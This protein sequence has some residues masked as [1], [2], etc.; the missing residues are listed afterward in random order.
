MAPEPRHRQ[1]SYVVERHV[2]FESFDRLTLEDPAFTEAAEAFNAGL[3]ELGA[4]PLPIVSAPDALATE[5]GGIWVGTSGAPSALTVVNALPEPACEQGFRLFVSEDWAIV[6]GEGPAGAAYGLA[7]LLALIDSA[8]GTIPAVGM[9]DWPSVDLRAVYLDEL[10]SQAQIDELAA[11]RLNAVVCRD[12]RLFGLDNPET[13]G[14]IA[15]VVAACRARHIEVIPLLDLISRADVLL[16]REPAMAEG[17]DVEHLFEAVAGQL[18]PAE[19]WQA[20]APPFANLLIS[21][22]APFS[23]WMGET[24]CVPAEDYLPPPPASFPFSGETVEVA[25]LPGGAIS[26]GERVLARYTAAL[27]GTRDACTSEPLWQAAAQETVSEIVTLMQPR[28]LHI[29]LDPFE[30][31]AADSRCRQRGLDNAD[32]LAEAVMLLDAAA[33][34]ADADTRLMAWGDALDPFREGNPFGLAA[35][36][37]GLPRDLVVCVR[38]F[39]SP[40]EDDDAMAALTHFSEAGLAVAGVPDAS[41]DSAAFWSATV[42]GIAGETALIYAASLYDPSDPWATLSAFAEAAWAARPLPPQQAPPP[43]G[44]PEEEHTVPLGS[45]TLAGLAAVC[46][47]LGFL[48]LRTRRDDALAEKPERGLTD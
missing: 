34:S 18:I 23:V 3:V 17:I 45:L 31:F 11:L 48:L 13:A 14:E 10:P 20:S 27:S 12:G 29:G 24:L 44:P 39:R 26:E 46:A 15:A 35:A 43:L 16:Q 25:T 9:S 32:L 6:A 40:E 7:A 8:A 2:P 21:P 5:A 1:W 38:N 28:Y 22:A 41:A 4:A 33:K 30:A 47:T 37:T 36:I 42:A 19:P